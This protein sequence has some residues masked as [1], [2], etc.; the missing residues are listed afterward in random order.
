MVRALREM[1][2]VVK[3]ERAIVLVVGTSVMRGENTLTH[4]CFMALGEMV[5]LDVVGMG[6]RHLDRDRRMMPARWGRVSSRIEKRMHEE[7]VLGFWK[8]GK[9][10]NTNAY[11]ESSPTRYQRFA[12]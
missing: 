10:V 11:R 5:G 9:G 6:I 3:P 1:R 2:R 4:E 12:I 8:R 7:Y